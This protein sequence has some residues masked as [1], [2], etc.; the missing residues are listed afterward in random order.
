MSLWKKASKS[1]KHAIE[2]D[3]GVARATLYR[4]YKTGTIS[5]KL[6]VPMAYHMDVNP[7]YLTGETDEPGNTCTEAMIMDFLQSQSYKNGEEAPKKS[8]ASA[9][10]AKRGRKPKAAA[11]GKVP[12]KAAETAA[13]AAS[14]TAKPP[15]APP[16]ASGKT[17]NIVINAAMVDE[18][19]FT[20]DELCLML[21]SV[22]L[23]E[24]VG[25]EDAK[26]KANVLRAVLL[27]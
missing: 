8:A 4:I 15:K 5:A 2:E 23:R 1:Q 26:Q 25:S 10:P 11:P 12:K 18:S 13:S 20:A 9:G 14:K 21:R 6:A 3:A 19:A 24:K 16:K 7:H 22:L 17:P 27:S